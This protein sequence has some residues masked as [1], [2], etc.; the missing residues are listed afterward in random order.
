VDC[1]QEQQR[2]LEN[3]F[4]YDTDI[5]SGAKMKISTIFFCALILSLAISN[6]PPSTAFSA[7]GFGSSSSGQKIGYVDVAEILRNSK[8]ANEI[9]M[10]A[11]RRQEKV[12]KEL[13]EINRRY[14]EMRD[15][16]EKKRAVL[17][18]K[19][20]MKQAEDL[21]MLEQEGN[22]LVR[23]S[24]AQNAQLQH[25]LMP[26]LIAKLKEIVRQIAEKEHYDYVMDKAVLIGRTSSK[27]DLTSRVL[28]ELNNATP[29]TLLGAKR[30]N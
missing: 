14:R 30:A 26:P 8:W 21:R 15:Q 16:F 27:E 20:R 24:Q 11:K 9:E 4:S 22:K 2:G 29:S 23:E 1:V 19:A 3:L 6:S 7:F 5:Y 12:R 25:E 18:A 13:S 28:T 10:V 17:S